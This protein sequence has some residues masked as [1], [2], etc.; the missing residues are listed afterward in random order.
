MGAVGATEWSRCWGIEAQR[1]QRDFTT[2]YTE[3]TEGL[4]RECR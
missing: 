4:Q 2:E 1:A 3:F